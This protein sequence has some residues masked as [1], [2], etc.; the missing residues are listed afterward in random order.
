MCSEWDIKRRRTVDRKV[1]FPTGC[2]VVL[3]LPLLLVAAPFVLT[4]MAIQER[5]QGCP[6]CGRRGTLERVYVG[7]ERDEDEQVRGRRVPPEW[8]VWQCQ[9]CGARFAQDR[10]LTPLGS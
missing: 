7:P 5:W 1:E 3:M 8:T 2:S 4:V 9:G 6:Q 10:T